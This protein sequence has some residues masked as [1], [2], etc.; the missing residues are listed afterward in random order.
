ML[1]YFEQAG[2]V[3]ALGQRAQDLGVDQNRQWLVEGADEVLAG[4][5]IHAGLAADR[6]VHL[7]KQRGR[8]L[9]DRDAAHE[10]GGQEAAHVGHDAAAEGHD[11]ARAVGPGLDHLF[12]QRLHAGEPLGLFTRWE[13]QD[14]M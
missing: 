13:E 8:D 2:T 9:D 4:Y 10:D 3:F 6:R 11:H 1:D 12:G 5:Q 7:G 14:F